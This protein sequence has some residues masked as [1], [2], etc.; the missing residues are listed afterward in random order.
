MNSKILKFIERAIKEDISQG[1]FERSLI[2]QG[3]DE[4]SLSQAVEEFKLR[5]LIKEAKEE[6]I[7][8]QLV[9]KSLI[10]HGYSES[11]INSAMGG[12]HMPEINKDELIYYSKIFLSIVFIFIIIFAA[13]NFL[14]NILSR[15]GSLVIIEKDPIK[16]SATIGSYISNLSTGCGNQRATI[17]GKIVAGGNLSNVNISS[18]VGN[19]QINKLDYLG[20]Y[21]LAINCNR[22][23]VL[24]FKKSGFVPIHK[25]VDL[26][27]GNNEL[28][29]FMKEETSFEDIKTSENS[30]IEQGGV[31]ISIP[32][33]SIV[34]PDGKDVS[35]AKISVTRFDATSQE[36]MGY[37]PGTLNGINLGG[38]IT[39]L[40]SFGFFKIKIED[41]NSKSLEIKKNYTIQVSFP[42]SDIQ[43]KNAP[44]LIPIWNF[45]E[46]LGTWVQIGDGVKKC[47]SG[48][49]Y[50]E[51]NLTR[52]GS[53]FGPSL[54]TEPSPLYANGFDIV[55]PANRVDIAISSGGGP[56]SPKKITVTLA[57]GEKLET[58]KEPKTSMVCE[59]GNIKGYDRVESES[60]D[61][62]EVAGFTLS[63]TDTKSYIGKGVLQVVKDE[64]GK[65]VREIETEC[66]C[67]EK[68]T[69]YNRYLH[70]CDGY[71]NGVYYDYCNSQT[72]RLSCKGAEVE[73]CNKMPPEFDQLKE[74]F[75]SLNDKE[76]SDFLKNK[77]GL[78]YDDRMFNY[79]RKL[80]PEE[81]AFGSLVTYNAKSQAGSGHWTSISSR[82]PWISATPR[83]LLAGGGT[84]GKCNLFAYDMYKSSGVSLPL[85][86][87][88]NGRSFEY[89][90]KL[91]AGQNSLS[92]LRKLGDTEFPLPGDIVSDGHH[93]MIVSGF[94]EVIGTAG[95]NGE[96]I[97]RLFEGA[98]GPN[99]I[100]YAKNYK[101]AI[102]SGYSEEDA[103][104]IAQGAYSLPFMY[105]YW[106]IDKNELPGSNK[107]NC[108]EKKEEGQKLIDSIKKSSSLN[109]WIIS[110]QSNN[111]INVMNGY[112]IFENSKNKETSLYNGVDLISGQIHYSVSEFVYYS[113]V[114]ASINKLEG[115]LLVYDSFI[116]EDGE[117][118]YMGNNEGT[119]KLINHSSVRKEDSGLIIEGKNYLFEFSEK[120]KNTQMITKMKFSLDN[121]TYFETN[122]YYEEGKLKKVEKED[123]EIIFNYSGNK[124]NAI[125]HRYNNG[126]NLTEKFIYNEKSLIQIEYAI[127]ENKLFDDNYTEGDN[128]FEIKKAFYEQKFIFNKGRVEKIQINSSLQDK[129][130]YYSESIFNYDK[131]YVYITEDNYT[132]SCFKG[133]CFIDE[134]ANAI[135]T[136]PKC[137]DYYP[138]S[139]YR[140]L[141]GDRLLLRVQGRDSSG[142]FVW[143][144]IN[145]P[146]NKIKT[147]NELNIPKNANLS[148]FL[149][150]N[151]VPSAPI[152]FM[153]KNQELINISSLIIPP[154]NCNNFQVSFGGFSLENCRFY[155][156]D[157]NKLSKCLI[158]SS[159]MFNSSVQELNDFVSSLD[160]SEEAKEIARL[161][162][163]V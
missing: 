20:N 31:N 107:K 112:S 79:L 156:E 137:L 95:S 6:G 121:G 25:T 27:N 58:L 147:I 102:S 139:Y 35:E 30:K 103:K 10:D 159:G 51:F 127:D 14:P 94:G 148:L 109:D 36:D 91:Y 8:D 34:S 72:V 28:D 142:G 119:F 19:L 126:D 131:N 38:G 132:A 53:W 23:V 82:W 106:R 87:R 3:M 143:N 37:F 110:A 43:E 84:S 141:N 118:Y 153:S 134:L 13:F 77:F 49:C 21:N 73:D 66:T 128:F 150:M 97:T 70:D 56:G 22:E 155:S 105:K 24:T 9:K 161:S 124:L 47:Y 83:T 163:K 108:S 89:T 144:E 59:K 48:K 1:V 113:R 158:G 96:K 15:N 122:Y 39:S 26:V 40:S 120:N 71:N 54:A 75:N 145:V 115:N 85:A 99:A 90:T 17:G 76:L 98:F 157:L 101:N 32:A 123:G 42:I 154:K 2:N 111:N 11:E 50:Y 129:S 135:T 5:K 140:A 146:N 86:V 67:E 63:T 4:V 93:V 45:D 100:N 18:N 151:G 114:P 104:K 130:S 33:D 62:D 65:V 60:S 136:S 133:L 52:V 46:K 80:S 88:E 7:N 160:I 74:A 64:N 81:F 61:S 149:E 29:I 138:E 12:F 68:A 57:S 69:Y 152:R 78:S 162:I 125:S 16:Y 117:N 41:E 55:A 92:G 44:K 116:L